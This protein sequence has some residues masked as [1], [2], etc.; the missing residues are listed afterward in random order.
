MSPSAATKT[1][2]PRKLASETSRPAV[3]GS[4]PS[5]V[6]SAASHP[7]RGSLPFASGR[8]LSEGFSAMR[9]VQPL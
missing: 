6:S 8:N 7:S 5:V 3:N 4:M 2:V 9:A 1:I